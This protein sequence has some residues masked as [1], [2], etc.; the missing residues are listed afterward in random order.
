MMT[1]VCSIRPRLASRRPPA[2]SPAAG[3]QPGSSAAGSETQQRGRG[4]QVG[5]ADR[6]RRSS[7]ATRS[8]LRN[9]SAAADSSAASTTSVGRSLVPVVEQVDRPGCVLGASKAAGVEDRERAALCVQRQRAAQRGAL[10]LAVDLEGVRTRLRAE[11]RCRRRPRSASGW[12]RRGRGP[13]P[14]GARASRRRRE[15]SPRVFVAAVP[16]LRAACSARTLWCTSGPGE[17]RRRR[18]RRRV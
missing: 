16:R 4:E 14:S 9:D 13:C 10:L 5:D 6:P 12:S 11:R 2:A 17:A 15:T 8:R 3:G 1:C 18:R 7:T